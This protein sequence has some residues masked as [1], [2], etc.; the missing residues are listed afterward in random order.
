VKSLEKAVDL[1]SQGGAERR[2]LREEAIGLLEGAVQD[3]EEAIGLW[4]DYLANPGQP[5]EP[6][7]SIMTWI[8]PQRSKHLHEISLRAQ[9]R[10]E[11][12]C[13]AAGGPAGRFAWL[14]ED[15]IEPPYRQLKADQ[16]GSDLA[17][18]AVARLKQR[19]DRLRSLIERLRTAASAA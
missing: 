18:E 12:V 17:N 15:L 16:S 9:A 19:I 3:C 11:R 1:I 5:G 14:E 6:G 13:K 4:Q 10:I 8:G 2:Q 7:H